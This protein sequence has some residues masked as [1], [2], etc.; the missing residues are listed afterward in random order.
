MLALGPAWCSIC[1]G[2]LG[3]LPEYVVPIQGEGY[4]VRGLSGWRWV[5]VGA[6]VSIVRRLCLRKWLRVSEGRVLFLVGPGGGGLAQL[7][8]AHCCQAWW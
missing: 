2:R 3:S 1:R 4:T 6:L 8:P 5:T 7:Q